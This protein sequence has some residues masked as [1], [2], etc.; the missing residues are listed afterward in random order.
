MFGWSRHG[1]GGR[2]PP[3]ATL[4]PDDQARKRSSFANNYGEAAAIDIYGPALGGP[5]A[6]A[7]HNS[8]FLWGPRGAS[9]DVVITLG[10]DAA[11]FG[12]FYD[13]V[14]AVGRTDS[15]YAMP[16]ENGPTIWSSA[17][18]ARTPPS[19]GTGARS[20]TTIER[21][22]RPRLTPWRRSRRLI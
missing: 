10:R 7:A 22:R 15:L 2:P 19:P 4:P 9:G 13:D 1:G 16:Y 3:I 17:S 5:S 12:R 6:I 8:Y 18:R 20:N 11:R 14:R 21:A